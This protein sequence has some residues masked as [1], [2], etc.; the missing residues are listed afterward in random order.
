MTIESE[1]TSGANL[2][3]A[4][5]IAFSYASLIVENAPF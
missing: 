2:I 4:F 5:G 3:L 1:Y